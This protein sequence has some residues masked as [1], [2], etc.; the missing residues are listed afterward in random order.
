MRYEV[1]IL[2][3]RRIIRRETFNSYE[4]AMAFFDVQRDKYTCEFRDLRAYDRWSLQ[5]A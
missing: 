1:T 2:D 4:A 3:G 5:A